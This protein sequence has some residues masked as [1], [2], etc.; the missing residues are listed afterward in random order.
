MKEYFTIGMMSGTSL[1]GIDIV[2]GCF[3]FK[4][5]WTAKIFLCD[6]YPYNSYWLDQLQVAATLSGYELMS[7]N[8]KYGEYLGKVANHFIEKHKINKKDISC[9]SSHGHTIFHQPHN[10]L[11]FQLGSG[12]SLAS[13]TG[14]KVVSDFRIMDIALGGQGAPLV[15]IGDKFLFNEYDYCL[16]LG[17]IANI[18][19]DY[20]GFRIAGDI[21]FANMASNYLV[22]KLK[23]NYDN[24]G[25]IA[26]SGKIDE[27]LLNEINALTYFDYP[28]PKSLGKEDFEDWFNPIL[29]KYKLSPAD[30]LATFGEHL[31]NCISKNIVKNKSLLITGGGTYNKYWIDILKNKYKINCII[32]DKKI[33]DFKEALIFAFL[34]LLRSERE[35]NILCSA[36]GASKDSIGGVMYYG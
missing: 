32:P 18:S 13:N 7:L 8:N 26:A 6:L 22:K 23:L 10:K 17:G 29:T 24:N 11:T 19:Y 16:N 20:K 35:I 31:A 34:G 4:E 3:Q 9:L 12:S 2:Y 33:I 27:K 15:P 30:K 21:C 5:K 14:L 25:K 1:D 28:L 36:T